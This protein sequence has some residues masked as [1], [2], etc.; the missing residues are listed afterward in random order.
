MLQINHRNRTGNKGDSKR[1]GKCIYFEMKNL[2]NVKLFWCLNTIL[3]KKL[4]NINEN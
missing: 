1:I 2:E 3:I 4:E